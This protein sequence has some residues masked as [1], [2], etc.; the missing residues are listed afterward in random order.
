MNVSADAIGHEPGVE[1]RRKMRGLMSGCCLLVAACSGPSPHEPPGL[2]PVQA[3]ALILRLLPPGVP[4]SNG[5]ATDVYAAFAAIDIAPTPQN[6]CAVLAVAQQESGF[7]VD[8]IIPGLPAIAWKEIDARA[9]KAGVPAALVRAAL[10]LPSANGK[11]YSERIDHAHSERDLSTIYDDMVAAVPGGHLFLAERN[12]IRTAGPMQVSVAF[13]ESYAAAHPYP[14]PIDRTLRRETFTRHGSVYFGT[15]HLLDY[16]AAYDRLLY[17][18]ADYNAG[19]Y[20]S[21]N[22]AFQSALSLVSGI[23]LVADGDLLNSGKAGSDAP[24]ATELAAR[25]AGRRLGL[26]EGDVHDDLERG[27]TAEVER[28]GLY[29][30]VFAQ[31]EQFQGRPV[32]RAL[33]PAIVLKGPKISHH[34]TTAWYAGRVEEHYQRCMQRSPA[35]AE[36]QG[37]R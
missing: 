35:A 8:P 17:R 14:Y 16:P 10:L 22:S 36:D 9:G 6:V 4:D 5:W 2:S 30:K 13:A 11:S 21:R 34:L 27:Q 32:S 37:G 1:R 20:A 25:V 15:A 28:T 12:P 3:H 26:S 23:P 33:V 29:Q 31:A 18:F 19:R 24:T 7:Q